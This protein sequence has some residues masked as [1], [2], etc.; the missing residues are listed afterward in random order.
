MNKLTVYKASFFM[1]IGG[2][3]FIYLSSLLN[4]LQTPVGIILKFPCVI[5]ASILMMLSVVILL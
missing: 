5:I 2:I 3:V 1:L 4:N